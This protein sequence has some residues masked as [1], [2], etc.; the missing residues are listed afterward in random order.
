MLV[1]RKVNYF[2]L[3]FMF[4]MNLRVRNFIFLK[5]QFKVKLTML[6]SCRKGQCASCNEVN[7]IFV[8]M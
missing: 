7:Y 1:A 8:D 6:V 5:V 3:Q 4:G 2:H